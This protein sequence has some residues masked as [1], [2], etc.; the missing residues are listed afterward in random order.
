MEF[1]LDSGADISMISQA[2]ASLIGINYDELNV[3]EETVETAN[4]SCA[5][6]KK[7][8][9]EIKIDERRIKIPVFISKQE[10]GCLLGRRGFFDAFDI[11]F[12]ERLHRVTLMTP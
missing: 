12:Q 3:R 9:L 6:T 5:Y 4:Y 2:K 11:L 10:V 1:L 8:D 7:I